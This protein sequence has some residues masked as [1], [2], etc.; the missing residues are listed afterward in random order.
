LAIPPHPHRTRGGEFR[1]CPS[2]IR[3]VRDKI[4]ANISPSLDK[5]PDRLYVSRADA[6]RRQVVNENKV[7]SLLE[8]YGFES[9]EP[10]QYSFDNQV[11]LFAEAD[12]IVGPHGAGLSNM[13]YSEDAKILELMTKESGEHYFV[14]ANECGHSYDLLQCEPKSVAEIHPRYRDMYVDMHSLENKLKCLLD[15]T[16]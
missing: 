15:D 5:S 9:I 8:K 14:L 7:V 13:I 16:A 3:W 11:Q 2:A 1:V 10:G 4:L 6:D 12:M